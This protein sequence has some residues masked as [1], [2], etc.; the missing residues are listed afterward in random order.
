MATT[1]RRFGRREAAVLLFT[2]T[3]LAAAV[4]AAFLRGNREFI[5][6]IAVMAVL[7][8][9]LLE[10]HRR[11]DL[12]A[13]VLWALSV[14]GLL[15]MAGGLVPVPGAGVLYNVW[16][17][18]ERLKF[19]QVVHA[20]GF[21]VATLVC[22]RG[23]CALLADPRPRLGPL[24]LAAAAGMG[25]GALNEVVEFVATLLVPETN[26]GGYVN[27]GWDLVSNLVGSVGAAVAVAI[28]GRQRLA[29]AS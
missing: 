17:I 3:Y 10:V 15:H 11:V 29:S 22:W 5:F 6:Y 16:I 27:T 9:A 8:A 2:G 19:D 26:V 20:Y 12:G 21:A 18:P 24:F 4:A 25:L 23:L 28:G 13:G 14:W 7:I 1:R